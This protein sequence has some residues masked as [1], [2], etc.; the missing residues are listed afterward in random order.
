MAGDTPLPLQSLP[1]VKRDGTAFEGDNYSEALWCRFTS[2]GLPRK[3]AGYQSVTSQLPEIVRGMELFVQGATAYLHMGSATKLTQVQVDS[4]SGVGGLQSDRTPAALVASADNLWQLAHFYNSVSG[5]TSIVAHPGQNLTNIGNDVQTRIFYGTVSATAIL[6]QSA[7]DPVSGG[8]LALP[9]Y[10]VAYGNSGRVDLSATNDPTAATAASAFI[11]AQKIVKGLAIRGSTPSAILWSLD[12]LIS[13]VFNPALVGSM[14]FDFNQ[15]STSISVLSSQAIIEFDSIY[16]WPGV[17]R[18]WIYNGVAQEL[19]ND[20]NIDFFYDNLNFTYAQK[21]FAFKVPRWGE[22]WFCAPLF[23][24]TE[25]NWAIIYNTRLKTW[26]DT[27]LPDGGR[28]AAIF[29]KVYRRPF[30]CDLDETASG[31]TLWQH[32]IG[33][34]KILGSTIEPIRSYYRTHEMS[35]IT[36]KQSPI[37]KALKVSIVEPDFVQSEDLVCTVYGRANAR[38]DATP[39][40]SVT[41]TPPPAVADAQLTFFKKNTRLCSFQFESNTAGGDFTAGKIIG[42]ISVTDGRMTQ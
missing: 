36:L 29:A 28:S 37:D 30:M 13:M 26:Y 4:L 24:S 19:P 20:L 15:I 14:P 8:I 2:R 11:T 33:V 34:D 7:M 41:I 22:I 1:G 31:F 35:P 23:D 25:P 42:H 38:V 3:I 16:Y 17:D 27:P 10:L 39:L 12:S 32:E 5:Q 21:A 40:A 6:L 9:P 18:F